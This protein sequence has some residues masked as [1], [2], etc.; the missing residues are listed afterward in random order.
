MRAKQLNGYA[1]YQKRLFAQAVQLL[2]PGGT[3]V[4][5]TC[6]INV[7]ENEQMVAWALSEFSFLSLAPQV[8]Q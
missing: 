3:L 5:S 1:I 8:C 6:T 7:R 4:Y 2:K